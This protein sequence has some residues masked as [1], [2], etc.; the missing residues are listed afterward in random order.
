MLIVCCLACT[1]NGTEKHQGKRDNVVDVSGK[2]VE[3]ELND[4][5][6]NKIVNPYIF[7]DYLVIGDSK[8]HDKLIYIFD[9]D[10]FRYIASVGQLGR[11][12]GE[13]TEMGPV[14]FD[15]TNNQ[16]LVTD[17]S[18]LCVFAYS[19]DSLTSN[20]Q[21]SPYIKTRLELMSCM[22]DYMYINDTLSIGILGEPTSNSTFRE[23]LAKWNMISG[24]IVKMPYEHPD[25]NI[26]DKHICFAVS[27]KYGLY[28]E[29]YLRFDLMTICSLDGELKY[30]IYGDKWETTK[31][32]KVDYYGK[33]RFCGDK[34]LVSYLGESN[35]DANGLTVYPTKFLVFDMNG[36]YIKTLETGYVIQYFCYDEENDRVI[37]ALDD[38]MQFAYLDLH[39]LF[40]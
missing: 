35:V 11:G 22:V 30:N 33:V 37:M 12:P 38:K 13:I 7:N 3:I 39:N 16:L 36:D 27:E 28:I 10:N 29:C 4:I 24:E 14:G 1:R 20:P 21:H 8:S 6:F 2:L 32:R 5:L 25:I 18:K 40:L 17:L 31:A 23:S 15:D 26:D 34:I 9:K 19:M